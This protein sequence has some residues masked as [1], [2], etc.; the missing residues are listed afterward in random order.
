MNIFKK[1]NILIVISGILILFLFSYRF[2]FPVQVSYSADVK[3]ILNKHCISCH[4]GVKKQGEFSLLFHEEALQITASGKPS[5]IPFHAE[6]SEF[7]SRLT[8]KDP[9]ERMPYKK[10]ALS[11]EEIEILKKW[12][13]QGAKW[14]DH[15][16][17]LPV[18]EPIIP[19]VSN[20]FQRVYNSDRFDKNPIDA[21]ILEKLKEIN[22]DPS[23]QASPEIL[24]RRVSLDIT[25]LPPS[26]ELINQFKANPSNQHY[27]KIVDSLL[28]SSA[29]GE[30]WASSWL[31]LARY[32]D[33]R[34]Y[35]KDNGRTIWAYRDWVIKSLNNNISFKDFIIKQ[36]AGDMIEN[37]QREDYIATGFH[38][39]TMNNDETG[40][41]DEEFR[42][43]A[44]LDRV[45]TTWD[46]LHGTTF[47]CV[48]C[49]SH[50]YDPIRNEEYYE[51]MAFLN[52]TRD[53]DTGDEAPFI[54]TFNQDQEK[55]I[56]A[57][58][59]SLTNQTVPQ[60]D[61]IKRF[62]EFFEP[63]IYAH[64]ADNF[65][66]GALN[67]GTR[68]GLRHK[69]SCRL[70]QISMN[71]K[72]KWLINYGVSQPGGILNIRHGSPTGKII[73]KIYLNKKGYQMEL[74]DMPTFD[75]KV[76][77]YLEAINPTLKGSRTDVINITWFALLP[78][79][80]LSKNQWDDFISIMSLRTVN[81]P[82]YLEMPEDYARKTHEFVRG[83]W[84]VHGKEVQP[85]V[86]EFMHSFKKEYPRNRL[87]LA[88][89][90]TD[91][92]NPLFARNM[93]NRFW[94]QL[95]GKGIVFTLEDLGSQGAEPTH[96]ELLD[97][98][99]YQFVHEYGF[100][101]KEI[102]KEIVL[103]NTYK[104]SSIRN[105]SAI[106]NDPE[107][108][109]LSYFPRVRLSSETIRDQALAVSG[110][111]NKKM[112]GKPIMPYQPDGIWQAVNSN[113][114]WNQD[115]TDE[116]YRRAIY[117][118]TRRTGPYPSQFT[119]DSPS[120][121]VCVVRRINT[122]TPL[123]ALVLLNDSAYVNISN[124]IG[125]TMKNHSNDLRLNIRH[126]YKNMVFKDITPEKLGIL[127]NLYKTS[128]KEFSNNK[129]LS[130]DEIK[131]KSYQILGSALI[132]LDE[133][134]TKE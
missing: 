18:K 11:Q 91:P 60:I 92:Q 20:F 121:E 8:S 106:K 23:D 48:Q 100:K 64:H 112:F 10:P 33:S 42:V 131:L 29:F 39:N 113:L 122:N 24:L 26:L 53:E 14:E 58:F 77:L 83:N 32:S 87:G 105:K 40:T 96:R 80:N 45:N 17:Y 114:V 129:S 124:H 120:R 134:I 12:V 88:Y 104:Q 118:F 62:I 35:Q 95:F 55:E 41:V 132:N 7:I 109:F 66:E 44:I 79:L 27:Q 54:R 115:S 71:G 61:F 49:H 43:A 107:N 110:L 111:L 36:L 22:L 13:N 68:I 93:V 97:Y 34:G 19:K 52:N 125:L 73:K 30:K 81:F 119:F 15:W 37:P 74:V 82:I 75:E 25:G 126:S 102:I 16:A 1:S 4:G 108:K 38:R 90:I 28:N 94:E 46:A 117:I 127:E 65:K 99:A 50:P 63:R 57:F 59:Q 21:Y 133:F 130:E 56:K 3:P 72:P 51:F 47:S 6:D 84:L 85:D 78:E 89:W 5:I 31:D 70:P 116:Q 9:E 98:L 76:D 128:W 67:G 69:G 123:Q 101:P 86:P 2:I 103:S